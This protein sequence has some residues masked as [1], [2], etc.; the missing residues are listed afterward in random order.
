MLMIV[1]FGEHFHVPRIASRSFSFQDLYYNCYQ[2]L[3]INFDRIS[4]LDAFT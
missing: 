1:G 3:M 4:T 2:M